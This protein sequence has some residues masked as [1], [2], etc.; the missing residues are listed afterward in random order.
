MQTPHEIHW[1]AAKRILRYVC[2]T[3]Q[4]KIH[5]SSGGNPLL[6]GFTDSD[7]VDDP[8]DR[9]STAGYVFNLGS[10]LVTWAYKKQQGIALFSAEVE[11]R[12]VVNVGQESLW[13]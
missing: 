1:K 7:W 11:Y 13:L 10:K 3:V 2:G 4:F 12:A 9:K 5:Y 6:F 8:D